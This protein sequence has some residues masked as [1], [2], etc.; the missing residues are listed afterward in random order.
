VLVSLLNVSDAATALLMKGFYT[1]W[2]RDPDHPSKAEALRRAQE[3]VRARPEFGEPK[4]WA[5]F[6]L[7][8][9]Q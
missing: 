1:H 8:G 9:A 5:A 7:V 4:Y 2:L 6:Q 3:E